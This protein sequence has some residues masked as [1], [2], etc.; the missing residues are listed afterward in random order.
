MIG[1]QQATG[2]SG[3]RRHSALNHT[4]EEIDLDFISR[5]CGAG[6]HRYGEPEATLQFRDARPRDARATGQ[7]KHSSSMASRAARR[8]I[9]IRI[10]VKPVPHAK[11]AAF[12]DGE[13]FG[14]R[15]F[16][17]CA[18]RSNRLG[19]QFVLRTRAIAAQRYG[20]EQN[21]ARLAPQRTSQR[22][23]A[24]RKCQHDLCRS[25]GTFLAHQVFADAAQ[26]SDL[27]SAAS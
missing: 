9:E 16:E 8:R 7:P 14:G 19:N 3:S 2:P 27:K 13:I 12:V 21:D 23:S 20:N 15:C 26:S 4:S 25:C 11:F 1:I 10:V 6:Q 5:G 24:D 17:H 22:G 18:R